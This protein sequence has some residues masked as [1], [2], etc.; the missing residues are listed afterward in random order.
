M[1]RALFAPLLA[2]LLALCTTLAHADTPIALFQAFRGQVN[3][4]GTEETLRKKDNKQ[5]CQLVNAGKGISAYLGGIPNGA[6]VL[7][8]QLYWAASGNTPD[9]TVTF[10]GV[11]TTAPAGRRYTSATAGGGYNYFS[12]AADVTSQV[13]SKGNGYYTFSGLSVDNGNP[14]CS[15]QGVVGGFS[16]LVIYSHPNE[17]YRLLNLYEGFQYFRNNGITLT[18]NNFAIPSPLPD[19]VTGRIGHITWEGDGTL[20]GGGEDL[21]FNGYAMTDSIN[22][23]GNQ[24]NSAS[25]VTGD[26]TSYGID[27]DAYTVKSPVIQPGQTTATTTYRSGQDMVLLSAEVAALPY[28]PVADLSLAMSR[29]GALQVGSNTTYTLTVTNGGSDTEI[30]PVTVVDTLPAGLSL[31]SA[32]GTG[33]TCKTAIN[34]SSQTIVTCTANGPVA[35]KT[36]MNPITLVA[37]PS[38]VGDYTNSATVSGQT[39]DNNQA[40]NTASDSTT[41]TNPASTSTATFVFTARA[42]G[43]SDPI[44][45]PAKLGCQLY[46]APVTAGDTAQIFL[47]YVTGPPGNYTAA[48]FSATETTV[49]IQLTLNCTTDSGVSASYAG[50]NLACGKPQAVTLDFKPG[51][52]SAK[53]LNG[54]TVAAFSYFDVGQLSLTASYGGVA[55]PAAPFV[56][57]PAGVVINKVLRSSDQYDPT[58]AASDVAFAKAGQNFDV[59]LAATMLNSTKYAPSFGQEGDSASMPSLVP[60]AITAT[61]PDGKSAPLVIVDPFTRGSAASP[62]L[63]VGTLQWN[64]AGFTTLS[65]Q[66]SNYLSALTSSDPTYDIGTRS[67][68]RFYPDH[69]TTS[70]TR[71]FEC[72]PAMACTARV[73]DPANPVYGVNGAAYSSQPIQVTVNAYGLNNVK[74][75]QYVPPQDMMLSA[76]SSSNGAAVTPLSAFPQSKAQAVAQPDQVNPDVVA[77]YQLGGTVKYQLAAPYDPASPHAGNWSKPQAVYVR[78]ATQDKVVPDHQSAA[79][80]LTITSQMATPL[81]T[82]LPPQQEDGIMLVAGRVFVGNVFGSELAQVPLP[83]TAQYWTGTQ[84]QTNT[85]DNDSVVATSLKFS[86]CTRAFA[87][88]CQLSVLPPASIPANGGAGLQLSGGAGRLTLKSPARGQTGSLDISVQSEASG[89]PTANPGAATWLPSTRG[90]ANF[91]LFKSPLIYLREV[92]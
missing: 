21:L 62:G 6:K 51:I 29:S 84:W 57:K 86:N 45:P 70:F 10:D 73:D 14:W 74:L 39:G 35:S 92:Y 85:N 20:S 50:K 40:N 81:P 9:Y 43:A 25:N 60:V 23:S 88:A 91:G 2:L 52:S 38:K 11:N 58:G 15:V 63:L 19:N 7:S 30:G 8:A 61:G 67:V 53:L 83:L 80:P 36:V 37:T 48:Q 44:V 33:W 13:A 66:V 54:T 75:Q 59:Q 82:P 47:T 90:R 77:A 22:P 28:V 76:V 79:Q 27:F 46:R 24:F 4:T 71:P 49:D 42:C 26:S 1:S 18:L 12:G 3:F 16:L 78:A 69:L 17:S 89:S 55:G 65:G 68:G 64:E 41:A 56:S 31:V 5:P 34:S 72:L 87:A 32:R